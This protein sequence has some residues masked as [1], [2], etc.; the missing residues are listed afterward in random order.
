M[1]TSTQSLTERE[2]KRLWVANHRGELARIAREL[3]VSHSAV[4]N[5]LN[6]NLPSKGFRIERALAEA[7]APF[8]KLRLAER[9]AE[10]ERCA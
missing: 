5:V 7:G 6:S 10:K 9:L 3:G 1:P 2:Q 8:M 4:W